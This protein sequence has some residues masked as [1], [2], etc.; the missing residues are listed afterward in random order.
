MSTSSSDKI[1]SNDNTDTQRKQD[2]KNLCKLIAK[3]IDKV[4]P[5]ISNVKDLTKVYRMVKAYVSPEV[6]QGILDHLSHY[7]DTGATQT[8]GQFAM[9]GPLIAQQIRAIA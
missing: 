5:L 1:N 3:A 2:L 6:S 8:L 4:Y 9:L 7:F